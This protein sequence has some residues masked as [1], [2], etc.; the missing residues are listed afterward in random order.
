MQRLEKMW[1]MG[2]KIGLQAPIKQAHLVFAI[3]A[4]DMETKAQADETAITQVSDETGEGHID[5]KK[6]QGRNGE[7]HQTQK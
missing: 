2:L 4:R 7:E 6:N 1:I 3:P 5:K